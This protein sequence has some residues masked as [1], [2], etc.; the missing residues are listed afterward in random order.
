[1]SLYKIILV[2]IGGGTGSLL[3]FAISYIPSLTVYRIQLA[4][5]VANI[6]STFI[7][8][9]SYK[10]NQLYPGQKWIPYFIMIGFCGGLSTFSTF[11]SENM[12]FLRDSQYLLFCIYNLVSVG[13]CLF[14]FWLGSYSI[15]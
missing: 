13:L 4:T 15:H 9:I 2:F 12:L 7:L 6:L 10:Y 14:A 11:S 3:R 5:L 8:G 1:M